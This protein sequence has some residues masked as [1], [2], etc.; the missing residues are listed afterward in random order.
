M[1]YRG[2]DGTKCLKA[3]GD[4]QKVGSE[5][6]VVIMTQN[7]HGHIPGQVQEELQA[8]TQAHTHIKTGNIDYKIR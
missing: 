2:K 6:E 4:I 3:H 5:E 1:C 8:H 7:R